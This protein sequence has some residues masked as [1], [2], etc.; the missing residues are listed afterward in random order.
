MQGGGCY[1][2]GEEQ[3]RQDDNTEVGA[4]LFSADA[5]WCSFSILL[6]VA[7]LTSGCR[8][9]EAPPVGEVALDARIP[10]NVVLCVV[11]A[12]IC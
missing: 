5:E 2:A 12:R 11:E 6:L 3:R 1:E 8:L 10:R 7:G 4:A 9:M